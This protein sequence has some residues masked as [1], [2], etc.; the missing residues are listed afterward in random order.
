[1]NWFSLASGLFR[2]SGLRPT[3]KR[4]AAYVVYLRRIEYPVCLSKVFK[5]VISFAFDWRMP[6]DDLAIK[7]FIDR[8]GR[9][10]L[11]CEFENLGVLI[12]KNGTLSEG[13]RWLVEG[14]T[15]AVG[16]NVFGGLLPLL[17][18]GE[19]ESCEVWNEEMPGDEKDVVEIV[20]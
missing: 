14:N 8:E 9:D 13:L 16:T 15:H 12:V 7:S 19:I 18:T 11:F 6:K 3:L 4:F 1:M 20:W 5:E 2:G 17:S 10:F